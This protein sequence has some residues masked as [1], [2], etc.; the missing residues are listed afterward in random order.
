[1]M[2]SA[3]EVVSAWASVLA[4]TK[5][6]PWRPAAIMLLTAL[7][8]APPTPNT[9]I[10]GF[11]S[12][13]SGIFKLMLMAASC[14]RGRMHRRVS[15]A[16]SRAGSENQVCCWLEAFAKPSSDPSDVAARPCLE[17]PRVPRLE[18]LQ[19]RE[20]RIRQEPRRRGECR[21]LG[22]VRQPRDTERTPDT[23]RAAEDAGG[24]IG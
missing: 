2:R 14:V 22:G 20:L 3:R 15:P 6:T 1:M 13:M 7:P 4:T 23:D 18:V 24:E 17:M 5:S 19:V 11:S 21:S 10:R 8:P 16:G 9:V 12:R